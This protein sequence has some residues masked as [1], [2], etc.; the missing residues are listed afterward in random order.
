MRC[1]SGYGWTGTSPTS[2]C[3][4]R[5]A[6]RLPR[7]RGAPGLAGDGRIAASRGPSAESGGAGAGYEQIFI[8]GAE[9]GTGPVT[10]IHPA[11][12]PGGARGREG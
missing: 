6:L 5:T 12:S 7:C 11:R 9:D 10:F 3:T 2:Q 4:S 8:D 1:S